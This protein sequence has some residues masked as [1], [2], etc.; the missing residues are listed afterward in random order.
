LFT[1]LTLN[2]SV[3]AFNLSEWKVDSDL[4]FGLFP[5]PRSSH[6]AITWR[7]KTWNI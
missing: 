5:V 4:N 1:N 6:K 3:A 2:N 7:H